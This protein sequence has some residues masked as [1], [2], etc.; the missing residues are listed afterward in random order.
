MEVL[1]PRCA[2]LDVYTDTVVACVRCVTA[3]K[4]HARS[5]K[6]R[7]HDPQARIGGIRDF[8]NCPEAGSNG[9]RCRIE[10]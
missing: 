4:L 2:G 1:Y 6:V 9:P 3:P 5:S 10:L 7:N 8:R